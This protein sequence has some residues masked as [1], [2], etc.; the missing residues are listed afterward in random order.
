MAIVFSPIISGRT[1]K[2]KS[3]DSLAS[4][5]WADIVNPMVSDAGDV[6]TMIDSAA[7]GDRKFYVIE[8]I[9]P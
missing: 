6:R 7:T 3:S 8:I 5:T 2:L 4:G 9:N 1:Y